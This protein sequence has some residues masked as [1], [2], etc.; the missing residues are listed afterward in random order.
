MAAVRGARS[1]G[2]IW[3]ACTSSTRWSSRDLDRIALEAL[4]A[5]DAVIGLGGGQAIDVAKFFAW[6][7]RLPLFQVPTAMTVNAPFGH[8]AG[9]R[10]DGLVRYLGWAVPEAVY[11]DLDVI[12]AGAGRRS[13]AAASATCSATTPRTTTGGSPATSVRRSR[14]GRTTSGS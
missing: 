6:R 4:P 1:T 12:Q 10:V 9:L 11:V 13:T 5:S 2:P 3:P 7:R 14:A 8:R